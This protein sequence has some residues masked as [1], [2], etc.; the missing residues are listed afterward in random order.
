MNPL[1]DHYT[2]FF[3]TD[4]EL[5]QP[6]AFWGGQTGQLGDQ[7]VSAGDGLGYRPLVNF[8]YLAD[9]SD[10]QWPCWFCR[11][12]CELFGTFWLTLE[13]CCSDTCRTLLTEGWGYAENYL[14]LLRRLRLGVFF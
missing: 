8:C 10:V 14:A 5:N 13:R 3:V 11:V 9:Y 4:E 2:S 12:N 7:W 1:R 6:I